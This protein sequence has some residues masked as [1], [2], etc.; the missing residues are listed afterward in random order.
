M[1]CNNKEC[2]ASPLYICYSPMLGNSRCIP[3]ESQEAETMCKNLYKKPD[4]SFNDLLIIKQCSE[5]CEYAEGTYPVKGFI[6]ASWGKQTF[7]TNI[8][9]E[10]LC[11][12][13]YLNV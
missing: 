6:R 11:F 12:L 8:G 2:K 4:K 1:G 13:T 7:K 3:C 10:R 9:Q 5:S